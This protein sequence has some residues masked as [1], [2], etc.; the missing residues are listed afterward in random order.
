MMIK[1]SQPPTARSDMDDVTDTVAATTTPQVDA[2]AGARAEPPPPDAPLSFC[3][4]LFDGA[5][6]TPF[7]SIGVRP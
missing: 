7:G 6:A 4:L 2:D 3:R 5:G 1:K